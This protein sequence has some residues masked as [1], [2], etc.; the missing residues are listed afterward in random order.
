[1]RKRRNRKNPPQAKALASY[2]AL[3]RKQA[4]KKTAVFVART[5]ADDQEWYKVVEKLK[6]AAGLNVNKAMPNKR[7]LRL[8]RLSFAMSV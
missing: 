3:R 1:M 6:H 4:A 2:Q 8:R 7:S 5:W